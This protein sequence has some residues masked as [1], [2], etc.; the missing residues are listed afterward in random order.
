[1]VAL[2]NTSPCLL[3]NNKKVPLTVTAKQCD[4]CGATATPMWRHGPGST[5]HTLCNS[6][7]VKWRRGKILFNISN[8]KNVNEI[9]SYLNVIQKPPTIE[10][11]LQTFIKELQKN[12]DKKIPDLVETLCFHNPQFREALENGQEIELDLLSLDTSL[13]VKLC[14]VFKN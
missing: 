14:E 6:C 5:Y 10:D 2:L 1:M 8:C 11:P 7:G 3:T 12:S 13:W 4:Y 9:D